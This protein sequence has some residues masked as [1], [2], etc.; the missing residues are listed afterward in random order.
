ML[1]ARLCPLTTPPIHHGRFGFAIRKP[2]KE[3][4]LV[5]GFNWLPTDWVFLES[6]GQREQLVKNRNKRKYLFKGLLLLFLMQGIVL[7]I[8]RERPNWTSLS[9]FPSFLWWP[10]KELKNDWKD[11]TIHDSWPIQHNQWTTC[12]GCLKVTWPL[13]TDRSPSLGC[14]SDKHHHRLS[15]LF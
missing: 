12:F 10:K 2:Q 8:A 4:H 13:L 9:L 3:S 11:H 7:C 14:L 5:E 6:H 1:F 15:A